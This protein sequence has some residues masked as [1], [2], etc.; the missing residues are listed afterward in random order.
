MNQ[1]SCDIETYSGVDLK[2]CGVYKYCESPDFEILLFAYSIDG[3]EVEVVDLAN[4]EEIPKPILDALTD[5]TTLKWAYSA[6]FERICLSKYLGLQLGTYLNPKSWRC[7]MVWGA[8]LGLPFSLAQV[9]AVLNLDNQKM[10]EG[11]ALIRYFCVPCKGTKANGGRTRNLPSHPPNKWEQ[12]KIYNKRDVEVEM[13]VQDKLKGFPV[14]DKI[15][16]EYQLDQIIND[17]GIQIDMKLVNQAM[18]IDEITKADITNQIITLTG[19]ENPNSVL[20]MRAWLLD[21]GLETD[22]LGKEQVAKLVDSNSGVL[23]EVLLLRQQLAKSSVKKYQAMENYACEDNRARGLFQFYGANRTGRWAGR[24]VQLQN[25]PKNH[26]E[27]LESARNLV[28]LGDFEGLT[29]I[30]EQIPETLSEL[31]RTAFTPKSGCKFIVADFS[32]IEARVIAWLAGETWRND[33]FATHGKIYEASAAQMFKVPIESIGKTSELRQKGKQSE[34]SCSYGGSVGALKKMG[35]IEMGLKESELK[36]LVDVWRA[37]NPNITK[38]WWDVDREVKYAV[39][40]KTTTQTYGITFSV[41]SGMLFIDLPSGRKLAY[42]KPRMG[43]NKFG[44]DCVTYEGLGLTKKWERLDSYGPKFV[45][46]IVQGMSRD[47]LMFAMNNLAKQYSIVAHIHDEVILEVAE[48]VEVD[49]VC[50]QMSVTPPWAGDL[51]LDAD[52]YECYFY[53]KA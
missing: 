41:K 17:R 26:I 5:D 12:F 15:W 3:G 49:E 30:Y 39:L 18:R 25:L 14:S 22:T 6:S 8:T 36:P 51:K 52:G 11:A 20:Q 19:L 50:R 23:K 16:E 45:E 24:G 42:V 53:K 38:L 33:V 44:G 46:N 37:A 7:S 4:G 2:K 32:A 28:R 48:D 31:I 35:A 10:K 13:S 27:D 34:L 47:I 1:L 40:H 43:I 29:M 9:G 21:N